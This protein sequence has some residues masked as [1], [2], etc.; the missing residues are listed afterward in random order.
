MYPDIPPSI[1]QA[2]FYGN[3][4]EPVDATGRVIKTNTTSNRS[5]RS[6]VFEKSDVK[7]QKVP[8]LA[9]P[10]PSPRCS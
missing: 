3:K 8:V 1:S 6:S 9:V 5:R 2:T 10:S 7:I 4:E